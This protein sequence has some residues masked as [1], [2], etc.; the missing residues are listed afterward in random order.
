VA[1]DDKEHPASIAGR[2]VRAAGVAI[3]KE[4]ERL[5]AESAKRAAEAAQAPPAAAPPVAAP[6]Q[7][8]APP[9]P[10]AP[11]AKPKPAAAPPPAARPIVD[12]LLWW[13]FLIAV[14]ST[15]VA[16][17]N[18]DTVTS[19]TTKVVIRLTLGGV[20]IF[21][22]LMLL[23]N[24]QRANERLVARLMKKFWGMDHP[25]T[26]SGRVVRRIARDLM[27]LLGNA[28]LAIGVFEILRAVVNT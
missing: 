22:S 1:V 13:G 28:W 6:P 8:V 18:V 14:A 4:K 5:A 9:P 7:A 20:F 27:I 17:L 15:A 12:R 21:V 3:R 10:A 19:G 23:T 11:A 26:R 2:Y 25:T 16:A 24:W